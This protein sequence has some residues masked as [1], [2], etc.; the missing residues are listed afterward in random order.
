M[1]YAIWWY[2]NATKKKDITEISKLIYVGQIWQR[3]SFICGVALTCLWNQSN[4]PNIMTDKL[5]ALIGAKSSQN[6]AKHLNAL[7]SARK[8]YIHQV[9]GSKNYGVHYEIKIE[10]V[11][12]FSIIGTISFKR[13]RKRTVPWTRKNCSLRWNTCIFPPRKCLCA[14]FAKLTL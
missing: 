12:V 14:C 5:P 1:V 7:H 11:N 10:H 4:L 9:N 2:V 3:I 13:W 8:A 6:F